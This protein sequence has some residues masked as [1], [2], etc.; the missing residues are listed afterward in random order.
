MAPSKPEP[1]KIQV[2]D[3]VLSDLKARLSRTRLPD[4]IPG[5]DWDYG[6][7]LS[8]LRDLVG[9]WRDRYDWRTHERELNRFKHFRA[10]VDGLKLHF[11]HEPGKGPNPKPLLIIHGW[12][13]SVYEFQQ[14]IPMLTDP[15]AHGGNANQSFTVI[16]PS[17]PGYGFSERPHA[18]AMN[19]QAI[20]ELFVKLMHEVLGYE[21][22]AVQGGDWGAAVTSRIG[23]AH[24]QSTL[25]I[26]VNMIAV[27][28][29]EGRNAPQPTDEEKKFFAAMEKFRHTE[30]G[31]QPGSWRSSAPGAIVMAMSRAV[32]VKTSC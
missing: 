31:S 20:A 30:T 9:Y 11:I 16:A 22:F 1:F 28:P 24:P 17:L 18:R 19:I 29:A 23:Y 32:S 2:A 21:K 3:D 25:G 8:Y 13:G 4:E 14:I 6:T 10:D 7:N 15:A 5:S 26:H 27:A 12:P